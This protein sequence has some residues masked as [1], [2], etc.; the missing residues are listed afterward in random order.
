MPDPLAQISEILGPLLPALAQAGKAAA[1]VLATWLASKIASVTLLKLLARL[2]PLVVA[3]SRKAASLTIWLIGILVL[4]ENL[5]LR[6]EIL[7]ILAAV[8]GVGAVVAFRNV[9]TNVADKYFSDVYVPFKVGD[10]VSVA[11]HSGV[12]VEINPV[13]TV[14]MAD[15]GRLVSVPNSFFLT[16]I[17]INESKEAWSEMAVPILVERGLDMAEVEAEILKRISKL[18]PMLD[19]RIPPTLLTRRIEKD[20][21]ELLLIARIRRPGDKEAVS[22]EINKRILEAIESVRRRRR[23]L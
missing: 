18:R 21:A 16:N 23:Q 13:V 20:H 9:I 19:E 11:G 8:G 17:V 2:P 7:A 14:L 3:H 22:S 5:G 10:R 15:D 6:I 1:I 12:V 4:V